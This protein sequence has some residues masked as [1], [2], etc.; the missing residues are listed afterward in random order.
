MGIQNRGSVTVEACLVVPLF[1]FF[2]LA[3]A[4]FIMLLFAEAHIHQCLA[5]AADYTAQYAYLEKKLL[6][7][8][9]NQNDS[10]LSTAILT[11]QFYTYLGEDSDVEKIVQNGKQG[12]LLSIKVNKENEKIFTAKAGYF[13][14]IHIPL[15]GKY[16]M[17][18]S[19]SVKQKAFLGYGREE[20]GDTY[21]YV[22]PNQA[23]YHMHRTC[24]HLSVKVKE[25]NISQ[26]DNYIPCSFCGKNKN[27]GNR[28]YVSE[29]GNVFH[30]RRECS[31]L[32]RTVNRVKLKEVK[33]LGPC[34]RCSR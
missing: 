2:M 33:S 27:T 3:I 32:K 4:D 13:V 29:T 30:Y 28:I 20:K 8:A 1:L 7:K 18:V 16:H 25:M 15:F 34:Q 17:K 11:K 23:V 6:G 21:V 14:N 22:T 31:G 5:D 26:K 10:I 12:I 24:S 9:G 19:N